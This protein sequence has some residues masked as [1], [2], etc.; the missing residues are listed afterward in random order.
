MKALIIEDEKAALRNLKAVIGEVDYDIDV[1]GEVDSIADCVDWIRSNPAPDLVFMDIHLA[2]GSAFDIFDIVDIECPV[3]F[4]TAYDEYALRAF[5]VNSVD[6]LLKPISRT[7]LKKALD[8]LSLFCKS[9][10]KDE[11]PKPVDYLSII[12]EL[13]REESYKT[14]FLVP[15]RD[16]LIPL[17]VDS[18]LYFYIAEGT[19]KAVDVNNNEFVFSQTLDEIT[20]QLNPKLFFRANRQYLIS[21]KSVADACVWFNGRLAINLKVPTSERIIISKAKVSEFKEWF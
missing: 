2:D 17:S 20:E 14:H 4:T 5:K 1:V 11:S 15:V 12:K 6:Y 8:K 19:V 16:K 18:I 7:E 13:K 3:I 10:Q 21:K 9:K